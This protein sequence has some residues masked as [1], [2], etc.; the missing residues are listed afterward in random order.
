MYALY[1]QEVVSN[2]YSILTVGNM[3]KTFL[4]YSTRHEQYISIFDVARTLYE[5]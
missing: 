5:V 4:T 1:L 2:L 3:D